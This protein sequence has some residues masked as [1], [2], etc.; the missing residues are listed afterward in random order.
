MNS[1]V[2]H[3][4]VY[5]SLR[6][7]FHNPV[8]DYI[9][10]HFTFIADGKT[11]GCLY[12]LGDY[13]VAAPSNGDYQLVGELFVA[14]SPEDFNWAISQ[15]DD[16]EGLNP[17]ADEAPLYRRELTDIFQNGHTTTAWIY[18]YNGSID[19][20]PIIESGDIMEYFKNKNQ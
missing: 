2:I 1:P 17:E 10:N 9:K 18:W 12:D 11:N 15:L 14:N 3:L 13:P 20:K 4:F 5:G 6:R 8:F 19:G 7:G 16:Y